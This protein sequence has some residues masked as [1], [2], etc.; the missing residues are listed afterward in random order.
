MADELAEDYYDVI[1][2]EEITNV[3]T[4]HFQDV[5]LGL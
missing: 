2:I 4:A 3:F 5:A 1:W